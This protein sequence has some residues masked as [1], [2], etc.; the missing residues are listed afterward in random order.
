MRNRWILMLAIGLLCVGTAAALED[1]YSDFLFK[2]MVDTWLGPD[3]LLYPELGLERNPATALEIDQ[4]LVFPRLS[5]TTDDFGT[6]AADN[7]QTVETIP[8][9]QPQEGG[10]LT[11]T[12]SYLSLGDFASGTAS[13]VEGYLPLDGGAVA[14]GSLL[15]GATVDNSEEVDDNFGT[16]GETITTTT[17]DQS[18]SLGATGLFATELGSF[19]VGGGG[20]FMWSRDPGEEEF[21]QISG[22]PAAGETYTTDAFA[23][24]DVVTMY[25]ASAGLTMDQN[26][27]ELGVGL[28][29]DFSVDDASDGWVSVDQN[30]NGFDESIVTIEEQ[31]TSTDPWGAGNAFY[32]RVDREQSFQLG[33]HPHAFY[34]LNETL[35]AIGSGYWYPFARRTETFYARTASANR[36]EQTEVWDSGLL[37]F[38]VLGGVEWAPAGGI[39]GRSGLGYELERTAYSQTDLD[40]GGATTFAAGNSENYEEVSYG[41]GGTPTN[42]DVI[43][44]ANFQPTRATSHL[45]SLLTGVMWNPGPEVRFFSDVEL[46]VEFFRDEYNVFNV[47]DDT[48]WTEI[49]RSNE[50]DWSLGTLV[51][52]AFDV[53]EWFTLGMTTSGLFSFGDRDGTR[54]ELPSGPSSLTTPGN[55]TDERSSAFTLDIF[56]ALGF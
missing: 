46:N 19:G 8:E 47:D 21:N 48:V 40:A 24:D 6:G 23:F 38:G 51:G 54:D 39:A 14:G 44:D 52:F 55:T 25:G 30:A 13:G 16:A 1:D 7:G 32:E 10:T 2:E 26:G 43:I 29:A 53:N 37:N 12:E 11:T 4:L 27:L 33:V 3:L 50:F 45:V 9:G 22:D 18:L 20:Y 15:F 34:D 41:V 31:Q 35:T 56:V 49:D 5:Y 36:N 42:D 17:A 28:T